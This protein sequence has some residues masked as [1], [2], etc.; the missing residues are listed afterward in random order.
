MKPRRENSAQ[1]LRTCQAH[2]LHLATVETIKRET[3]ARR[4]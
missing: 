1:M 4:Q 3:R 2:T